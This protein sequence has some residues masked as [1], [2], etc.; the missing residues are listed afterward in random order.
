[1]VRG[2]GHHVYADRY[3]FFN[4]LVNKA[5]QGVDKQLDRISSLSKRKRMRSESSP[6][7]HSYDVP[8]PP[9][10]RKSSQTLEQLEEVVPQAN[11]EEEETGTEDAGVHFTLAEDDEEEEEERPNCDNKDSPCNNGQS[12]ELHAN[13]IH[14]DA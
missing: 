14:H 6:A 10:R 7:L 12:N 11:E 4:M 8:K 5:C 3:D 13:G 2:A 9:P 1:M